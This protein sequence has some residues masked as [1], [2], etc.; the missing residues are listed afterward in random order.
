MTEGDPQLAKMEAL[1]S[2]A[3]RPACLLSPCPCSCRPVYALWC[4]DEFFAQDLAKSC[5]QEEAYRRAGYEGDVKARRASTARLFRNVQVQQRL[6]ELQSRTARR[7]EETV[8]GITADL[9]NMYEEAW[10]MTRTNA[11]DPFGLQ[12]RRSEDRNRTL[13]G[14]LRQV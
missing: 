8:V 1:N 14:G 13:R 12:P 11:S 3:D 2:V 10:T 4:R 5:S 9:R 7:T 6:A